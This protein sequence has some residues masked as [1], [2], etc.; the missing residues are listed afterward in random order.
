MM[1]RN[2]S[3][4]ELGLIAGTRMALGAGLGLLLA[5]H[6]KPEQKRAVGWTLLAVG[7]L[8][9]FP[10]AADVIFRRGM[11]GPAHSSWDEGALPRENDMASMRS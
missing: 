11:E 5:D 1:T 8:S 6:L 3:V 7:I 4:P 9:T 10:L 2:V